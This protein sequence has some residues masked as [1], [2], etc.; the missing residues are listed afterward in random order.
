MSAKIEKWRCV[1]VAEAAPLFDVVGHV[2]AFAHCIGDAMPLDIA[3]D[4]VAGMLR[5]GPDV[6]AV[7]VPD[8]HEERA[9]AALLEQRDRW[10]EV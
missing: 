6:V 9:M 2:V 5:K 8:G 3:A 4:A 1:W 10:R 7:L